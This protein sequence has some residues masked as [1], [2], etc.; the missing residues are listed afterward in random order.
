MYVYHFS[1]LS[2]AGTA[3]LQTNTEREREERTRKQTGN[4]KE[5]EEIVRVCSLSLSLC[6]FPFHFQLH[7]LLRTVLSTIFGRFSIAEGNPHGTTEATTTLPDLSRS[8]FV[9]IARITSIP[10]LQSNRAV[11]WFRVF[12][13]EYTYYGATTVDRPIVNWFAAQT[14]HVQ[15]RKSKFVL[16]EFEERIGKKTQLKFEIVCEE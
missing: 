5:S 3:A 13:I 15:N 4:T 16:I 9:R 7:Y 14:E 8:R 10:S 12:Y 1:L 2:R 11:R 6:V